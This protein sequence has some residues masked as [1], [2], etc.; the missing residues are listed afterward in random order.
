MKEN[1]STQL[2]GLDRWRNS[3]WYMG[4]DPTKAG[5]WG[6]APCCGFRRSWECEAWG[7][8][9]GLSLL[10]TLLASMFMCC[11]GDQHI[12]TKILDPPIFSESFIMKNF[13]I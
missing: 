1:V 13:S 12:Q 6:E 10:T 2:R 5:K 3:S 4:Q 7:A 9:S 11:A 8:T